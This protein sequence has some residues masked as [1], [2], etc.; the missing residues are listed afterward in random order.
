[1]VAMAAEVQ[2]TKSTAGLL[3]DSHASRSSGVRSRLT[4]RNRPSCCAG[5]NQWKHRCYVGL[6][7][8]VDW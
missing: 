8:F 5:R 6:M 3:R 1:M 2:T 7:N 4:S